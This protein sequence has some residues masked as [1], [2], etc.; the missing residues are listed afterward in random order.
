MPELTSHDQNFKN[1]IL[2]Y[3]RQ[4]LAFFAPDDAADIDHSALITPIRQ[5]L[6]K[7]RLGDRFQEL[8]VPL[9]VEW[10]DGRQ[11]ALLFLLEEETN[12][13]RFSIYRLV[14]YCATLAEMCETDRVIP[15]VIFLRDSPRI[16]R[17][18]YLGSERFTFLSFSY[19][20]CV[21]SSLPAEQYRN[22]DNI[23]ARIILPTMGYA[24]QQVVDIV[25]WA[26]RGLEMEPNE[27]KRFK[28]MD[29]IDAYS[30]LDDNERQI[31]AQRYPQEDT[32]MSTLS[33]RM[34]S[35]GLR[36]GILLGRQE[37]RQ[38]GE[39]TVLLRQL[40]RR[41]GPLS[42]AMTERLQKASSAELERWADN[43]L[44]ARSLEEV[45]R[46]H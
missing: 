8:D 12:P 24:R 31:F 41:F 35:E 15:V 29:F 30:S 25:A 18:L 7:N 10:P 3:P 11:A 5:E 14:S 34:R 37:G 45:F 38:E 16:R 9:K 43:V 20:A 22:S 44:D 33:Q 36:E 1:L 26:L 40:S 4:A 2:D 42:A 6:L 19:I 13:D 17:H 46:A 32:I 39:S 23:V 28:Y 27:E 21:L